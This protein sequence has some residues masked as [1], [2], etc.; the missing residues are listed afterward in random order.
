ML[1]YVILAFIKV[2]GRLLTA[3]FIQIIQSKISTI[4]LKLNHQHL[5]DL[6]YKKVKKNFFMFVSLAII[7][8]GEKVMD[9]L[10]IKHIFNV[11]TIFY[12]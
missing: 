6:R 4:L 3:F 12:F 8:F 9:F 5:P 11:L 1:L 10:P 2:A 7:G